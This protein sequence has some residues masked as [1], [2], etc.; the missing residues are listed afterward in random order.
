VRLKEIQK[1]LSLQT[2]QKI[3]DNYSTALGIPISIRNSEG[4]AL[5][6]LS[7]TS[8]LWNFIHSKPSTEKK[9]IT[10]LKD[11]IEKCNRTGQ[12]VI[13]ERHPD[14]NAFLAPIISNGKVIAYF[15][16]GLV[17]FGNPN[18]T[19]AE[20][21]ADLLGI[22]LDTYL[23]AYLH[24]PFF[25]KERLEASANLIK[26]IGSAL[27]SLDQ[28]K[29]DHSNST[30]TQPDLRYKRFFETANDGISLTD[31]DLGNIIDMN[32]AGAQMMGYRSPQEIIGQKI[33]SYYVYPEDRKKFLKILEEK[34]S[35]SNWIA[36]I[37]T[38]TGQEKYFEINATLIKDKS[39]QRIIQAVF[40]DLNPR[41]HRTL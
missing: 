33:E 13:F 29:P 41:Q 16:G 36:H 25:T 20:Q 2:L 34:G 14:T 30:D 32:K 7:N 24:L 9:L 15:V 8:K 21:Q 31:F 28:K 10:I 23:D 4:E 22:D 6:K 3:Q 18:M 35:I 12:V 26:I 27:S 11:A 5:T 17:R 37:S 38:V 39:G 40:R 1:L 19:I